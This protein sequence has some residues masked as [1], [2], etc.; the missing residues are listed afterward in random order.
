MKERE[1]QEIHRSYF[2]R[3]FCRL[4]ARS[5]MSFLCFGGQFLNWTLSECG[6]AEVK[7]LKA[8]RVR[9][10]Y[11]S[12]LVDVPESSSHRRW[13]RSCLGCPQIHVDILHPTVTCPR[14]VYWNLRSSQQLEAMQSG[15]PLSTLLLTIV[16]CE[17]IHGC[18]GVSF[19]NQK[20]TRKGAQ[21]RSKLPMHRLMRF[22]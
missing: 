8:G 12:P 1:V 6:Q 20:L 3:Y 2:M 16:T 13:C 19:G 11:S 10:Y 4:K 7:S 9:I 18:L 5:E 22:Q 17:H 21:K 14:L 15:L